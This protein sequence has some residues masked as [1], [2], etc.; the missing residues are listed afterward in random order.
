[1]PTIGMRLLP[2]SSVL[3]SL[4]LFSVL[5]LSPSLCLA[6]TPDTPPADLVEMLLASWGQWSVVTGLGILVAIQ[7]WRK[8]KPDVWDELPSLV[9]RLL[10]PTI[11]ALTTAAVGLAAGA[12]WAEFGKVLLV[13]WVSLA[14]AADVLSALTKAG[15]DAL[16]L[17]KAGTVLLLSS[18]LL[19]SVVSCSRPPQSAA[20][21]ERVTVVAYTITHEALVG[22]D[23]LTGE[24]IDSVE[25]PSDADIALADDI[26]TAL[27]T[28]RN[29][30]DEAREKLLDGQK[31]LDDLRAVA[32]QLSLT[33]ELL[34]RANIP[35]PRAVLD[36]VE[37]AQELLGER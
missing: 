8:V 24:W 4:L 7:I 27:K 6:Q 35:V 15:T 30:L 25:N 20:D 3:F 10:P 29:L 19:S 13:Q 17:G 22:A 2:L 5:F 32:G 14:W 23:Q 1:M 18:L 16:K 9:K 33:V 36:A 21:V 31:V 28:A 12:S 11:S 26:V 37:L 34:E